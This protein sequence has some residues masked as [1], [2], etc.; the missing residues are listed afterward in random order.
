MSET[1]PGHSVTWV[2]SHQAKQPE[3]ETQ[4]QLGM[5]ETNL[6]M[7]KV[8]IGDKKS[9]VSKLLHKPCG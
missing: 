4:F 8:E 1:S 3:L 7:G 2:L 9:C 6:N 5:R